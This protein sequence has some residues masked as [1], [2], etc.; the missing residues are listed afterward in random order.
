MQELIQHLCRSIAAQL[1]AQPQMPT[2]ELVTAILAQIAGD[3]RL[4]KEIER[5][6]RSIQ[7]NTGNATGYQTILNGGI[8][9]IGKHYHVNELVAKAA[10]ELLLKELKLPIGIP[11]NINRDGSENFVGR[12]DELLKLDRMLQSSK[13]VAVTAVQGMGGVGKTELA[14][15]YA[16][17]QLTAE[18][19]PGGIC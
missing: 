7:I 2:A 4:N 10:I 8:A 12:D 6:S 1:Q 3:E 16:L 14:L 19:H 18:T 11:H 13:R 9:Y 17:A 5:Q 15:Q